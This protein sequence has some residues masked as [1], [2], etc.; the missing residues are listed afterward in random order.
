MKKMR[1]KVPIYNVDVMFVQIEKGD[2]VKT[3]SFFLNWVYADDE[4]RKE[5]DDYLQRGYHDGGATYFIFSKARFA[6]ICYPTTSEEKM[7]EL[8]CHEKRHLEDRILE[9]TNVKDIESSAIL[10]GFLGVKMWKFI[11][12]INKK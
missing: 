4:E 5:M 9:H 6:I 2:S 10:A 7:I 11:N 8:Y 3:L 1:F 12:Y